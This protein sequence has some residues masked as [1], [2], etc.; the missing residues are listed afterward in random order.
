M[1]PRESPVELRI[2][3]EGKRGR[4]TQKGRER[5]FL[6]EFGGSGSTVAVEEWG[7]I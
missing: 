7:G 3:R 4:W 1:L 6:G 5:G 2:K